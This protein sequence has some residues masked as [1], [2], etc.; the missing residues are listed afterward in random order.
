MDAQ[1]S[2]LQPSDLNI[3]LILWD[4]PDAVIVAEAATDRIVL[5]NPTAETLLGYAAEEA[6]G[7]RLDALVPERFRARFRARVSTCRELSDSDLGQGQ[8][9]ARPEPLELLVVRKTG[10]EFRV[11]ASLSR[12][13]LAPDRSYV[14]AVLR[15]VTARVLADARR[16]A[17]LRVARLA[18]L[19][20][21]EQLMTNLLNEMVAV[22]GGD[23]GGV[24]LWDEAQGGLVTVRNSLPAV[25]PLI[26]PGQG[27]AG[28]VWVEQ[29]PLI[30]NDY[31]AETNVIR[32][33]AQAG[34]HAGVVV[35]LNHAGRH[36]GTLGISSYDPNKRFTPED[37]E[38]LELLAS[39]AAATLVGLER[40]RQLE[41]TVR[42]L[43]D[44][45]QR[46]NE[47]E[48]ERLQLFREQAA[49]AQAEAAVR[50]R[51]EFLSIAAHELKTPLTSLRGSAQFLLRQLDQ[52]RDLNPG[53]VDRLLRT[54]DQQSE[55]LVRLIS[56]L[57]DVSRIE[58]GRLTL[59]P[60][61]IDLT[62]LVESV[63]A[64]AQARTSRHL[65]TLHAPET[66]LAS[67][68]PLRFEQVV[69]NLID[70]AI[71][72]S[73]EGGPIDVEVAT[74][75]SETARLS[76]SDR[77]LG[78]EPEH[79]SRIFDR[80]YQAR[81]GG[82]LIGL[83]LGLY[84]SRQIVELH[85]GQISAEFPAEGGTRFVVSVPRHGPGTVD[86]RG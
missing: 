79:R 63:V 13:A 10:Q 31:Q 48:A 67:V 27:G 64:T 81:P 85:G 20:D 76:V 24:Y 57:L 5:W 21:A 61:L 45:M 58:A 55:K 12:L 17:L 43:Q 52:G 84:I 46:A 73:P 30:I 65:V 14:L 74:P 28:R 35:P 69:I 26:E 50:A 77:G 83:G 4:L 54:I 41:E 59:E 22:V 15:D 72:Y 86:R 7:Q 23:A 82:H 9:N 68:D 29:V 42:Q 1:E 53:Q 49:R 19:V 38:V 56:Q 34:I 60:S 66:V 47:A 36:L 62:R 37:V 32:E 40:S 3:G 39:T 33:A 25:F 44:A 11:E 16:D 78:I 2:S 75:D 18:G 70:N 51:D 71:K 8:L 6:L 80:F